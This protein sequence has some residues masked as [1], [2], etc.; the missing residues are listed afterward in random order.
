M[1]NCYIKQEV[2]YKLV[3]GLFHYKDWWWLLSLRLEHRNCQQ[4]LRLSKH[5][6]VTIHWKAIQKHFLMVRLVFR[7]T[8]FRPYFLNIW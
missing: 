5:T 3:L 7:F 6:D 8:H 4:N 1:A 2:F